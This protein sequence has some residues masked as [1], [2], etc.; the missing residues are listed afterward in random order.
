MHRPPASALGVALLTAAVL[1][2]AGCSTDT[3]AP[4]AGGA[5]DAA[6]TAESAPAASGTADTPNLADI[7]FAQMMIVHHQGA[8]EMAQL[9]V[10]RAES[11]DVKELA[12]RI[13]AAQQPEIEMM[14]SWL[15]AWGAEPLDPA[16]AMPGMD[17][18]SMMDT[19][20]GGMASGSQMQQLQDAQGAE[21]DTL[22]LQLMTVHHQGAVAMAQAE[23]DNGESTDALALAQ[24]VI[25]DQTA[26]IELMQGMLDP[27]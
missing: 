14:Q 26:E 15:R 2:L 24:Q 4:S 5:S 1:V 6:T 13:E 25:I 11:P 10:D 12:E 27:K 19:G 16:G 18:G 21:F 3:S 7:E 9:A 20:E 17:H 8:L 22:F 23:V